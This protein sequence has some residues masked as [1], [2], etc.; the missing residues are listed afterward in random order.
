LSLGDPL[1]KLSSSHNHYLDLHRARA[2]LATSCYTL[3]IGKLA[4]ARERGRRKLLTAILVWIA[5]D[6]K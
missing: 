2:I 1:S 3:Y 4:S 6:D 5:A